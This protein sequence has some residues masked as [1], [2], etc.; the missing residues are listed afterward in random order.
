MKTIHQSIQGLQHVGIPVQSMVS[1]LRFYE[2]LGFSCVYK[3]QN[4]SQQVCFLRKSGLTL[5]LYEE[6]ETAG[7]PG[8][9]DHLALEAEH[10]DEL[11]QWLSAA[12]Y[13]PLE[14]GVQSLPFWKSGVRF[15]TI[16]GP[17]GEKIEFASQVEE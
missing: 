7:K 8:A 5:E 3:T 1:S 6:A 10:L 11:C 4:G 12:G 13:P 9:I 14:G 16:Q 17:N 15:F 2:M